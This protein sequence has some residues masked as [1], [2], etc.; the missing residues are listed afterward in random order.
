MAGIEKGIRRKGDFMK[1]LLL[2]LVLIMA[3]V[4]CQNADVA[5]HGDATETAIRV[6]VFDGN[7]GSAGCIIDAVESLKIDPDMIVSTITANEILNGKLDGLDV[8][9]IPGGSGSR[10]YADLGVLGIEEIHRFIKDRGKGIVGLCAG[11]Y[12]LTSTPDYVCVG[13]ADVQATDIV[14]DERGNGTIAFELNEAGR[15]F[16]P[17]LKEMPVAYIHY[18][19]GPVLI[20]VDEQN[21]QADVIATMVSDVHLKNDAPPGMTPGKPFFLRGDVG[22]GRFFMAIGHPEN[23]PGM[24][25][26][27]P[28]MVRWTLDREPVPYGENVVRPGM[29]TGE[30]LFDAGRRKQQADMFD[31][32]VHGSAEEKVIAIETLVDIKSFSFRNYLPGMLRDG[33]SDVR[34]AAARAV[35]AL[36]RTE[37]IHDLETIIRREQDDKVRTQLQQCLTGLQQILGK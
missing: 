18:Y 33:S 37:C 6:A 10:Q 31:R 5:E 16:F 22:K 2:I 32:L 23:T 25:W 8:L 3:G 21:V 17:E 27:V 36:E 24:R 28:R 12:F 15:A 35:L 4:S 1:R 13:Y 11:S 30:I 26:M 14:H 9:V 20:P 19:E 34:L 29:Y 7:G